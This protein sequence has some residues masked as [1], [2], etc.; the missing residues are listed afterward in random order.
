MGLYTQIPNSAPEWLKREWHENAVTSLKESL[1]SFVEVEEWKT[2]EVR[3]PDLVAEI[4]KF[5]E[6]LRSQPRR[7]FRE[8]RWLETLEKLEAEASA[9]IL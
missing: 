1:G 6:Q 7:S 9:P 2:L 8:A 3:R 4:R 5:A